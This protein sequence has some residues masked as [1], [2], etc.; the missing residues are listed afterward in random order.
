M[1]L[2]Y[3]VMII[4]DD[5]LVALADVVTLLIIDICVTSLLIGLVGVIIFFIKSGR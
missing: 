5:V 4:Y 3:N 1:Q 2:L